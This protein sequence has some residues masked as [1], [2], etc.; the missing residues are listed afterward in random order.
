MNLSPA[1]GQRVAT[2]P[3]PSTSPAPVAIHQTRESTEESPGGLRGRPNLRVVIPSKDS[4]G[5]STA[6]V[7]GTSIFDLWC[8]VALC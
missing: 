8:S 4:G 3:Q 2:S 6:Q 7:C 5:V 1:P